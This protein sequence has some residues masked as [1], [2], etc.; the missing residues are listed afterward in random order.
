MTIYEKVI[1]Q[2]TG[3]TDINQIREVESYM[4]HII[5][6]STLNWQTQEQ[7]ETAAVEAAED[8]E[9]IGSGVHK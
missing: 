7:L 2:A 6:H 3:L 8:L 5:F 9:F 1:A 4:R